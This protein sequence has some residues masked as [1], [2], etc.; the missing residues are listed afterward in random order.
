MDDGKIYEIEKDEKNFLHIDEQDK[1]RLDFIAITLAAWLYLKRMKQTEL[2][3][4]SSRALCRMPW[5]G[6]QIEAAYSSLGHTR[7]LERKF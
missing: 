5:L 1:D 7:V 3:W 6:H 2:F 4:I